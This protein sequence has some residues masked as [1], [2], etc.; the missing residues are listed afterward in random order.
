MARL[1]TDAY[2]DLPLVTISSSTS[3]PERIER[4]AALAQRSSRGRHIVAANSGHWIPL[5]Q[6]SI[7]I[8]EILRM[9]AELRRG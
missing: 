9:V 1:G 5:D 3:T 8:Q 2:R 7:V 4:Q 6:P